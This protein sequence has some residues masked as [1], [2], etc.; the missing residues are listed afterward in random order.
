MTS[1]RSYRGVFPVAPTIFDD[2]GNPLADSALFAVS[3]TH[4]EKS[5]CPFQVCRSSCGI[6]QF[7]GMVSGSGLEAYRT[8]V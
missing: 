1:P 4:G 6:L 3:M 8:L 7:T 5:P 2:Q